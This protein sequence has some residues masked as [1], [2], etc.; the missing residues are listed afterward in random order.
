MIGPGLPH[1]RPPLSKRALAT[2]RLPLLADAS[3]A[4]RARHRPR[5]RRRDARSTSTAGASSC[6][7]PV[8][9]DPLVLEAPTL[10]WATGLRY[11]KPPV[12]GLEPA[13]REHHGRRARLARAAACTTRRSACRRDRRRPDRHRDGGDAGRGPRGDA[14]RHA[15]PPA[16]AVPAARLRRGSCDARTS[17]ASRFAR[18]VPDRVGACRAATAAPS[19]A[20]RRTATCHCD[21]VVSAA[22][23]RSSLPPELAGADPPRARPSPPTRRCA[24][25]ATTTCGRAATACRS[26]TR[27]AAGS[28]SRTGITRSG[29]GG[30]SPTAIL[31]SR[32][33]YV[34]DPYF[35]SDIGPLRIQQVGLGDAAPSSGPTRTG[36]SSAATRRARQPACSCSTHPRASREARELVGAALPDTRHAR[37]RAP[38][39]RPRSSSTPTSASARASASRLDPEAIELDENGIAHMLIAELDEQRAKKIC[40]VCPVGALSIAALQA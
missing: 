31:G 12:P 3:A 19:C 38:H 13:R 11:P 6:S 1:D 7:P 8:R 27:A 4:R 33:P 34:R 14:A 17:S 10:V 20:P 21:V 40:D 29:A 28:P 24:S 32:D 35:F 25:W 30:T 16:R 18:A 37:R 26:R 9:G 15:R 39:A 23:F 36:W 22:G 5:R 2:G